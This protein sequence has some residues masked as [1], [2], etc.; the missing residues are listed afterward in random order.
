MCKTLPCAHVHLGLALQM[1]A[2]TTTAAHT[3]RPHGMC[4]SFACLQAINEN[5]RQSLAMKRMQPAIAEGR[6]HVA[7]ICN[8]LGKCWNFVGVFLNRHP[9]VCTT[10][11]FNCLCRFLPSHIHR[12][13]LPSPPS[14]LLLL[15]FTLFNIFF[16]MC[17]KLL[18]CFQLSRV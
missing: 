10:P 2:P 6:W 4:L 1:P 12:C 9:W 11:C 15:A 8:V 13:S 7:L 5:S 17:C 3:P 16:D 14:P 18:Q